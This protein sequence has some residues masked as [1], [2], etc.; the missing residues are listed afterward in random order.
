MTP[1]KLCLQSIRSPIISFHDYQP[2]ILNRPAVLW[3]RKVNTEAWGKIW[4]CSWSL[5]AMGKLIKFQYETL[6][7]SKLMIS[8]LKVEISRDY[9]L[10]SILHTWC[11][12]TMSVVHNVHKISFLE[13]YPHTFISALFFLSIFALMDLPKYQQNHKKP[14]GHMN[15][16]ISNH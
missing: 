3:G 15:M 8:V 13:P 11:C 1:Q 14:W 16:Y 12:G 2:Q 5:K 9:K 10:M 4:G 6:T 7:Q